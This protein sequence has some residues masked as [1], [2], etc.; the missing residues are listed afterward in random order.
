MSSKVL[1]PALSVDGW[2]NSPMKVADL[3]FSHFILSDFSQTY[4]YKDEV[5]SLPWIIQNTQKDMTRTLTDV[6][7]TISRYFARYFNN[8]VAEVDEVPNVEEPSKAQ[9]SIY[10]RFTDSEGIDYVL[11][12]LIQ[13]IDSKIAEVITINNGV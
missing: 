3:L 2:A 5:S 9:I 10:L 7:S 6:Q 11:G 4:L 13:I 8:V 1:F 12:R